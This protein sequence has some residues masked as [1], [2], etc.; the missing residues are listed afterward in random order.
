MGGVWFPTAGQL[1]AQE[2]THNCD[3]T[4]LRRT[5]AIP[6][7]L[8]TSLAPIV[9][10]ASLPDSVSSQLMS[11]KNLTGTISN[12]DLE[13]AATLVHKDVTAQSFGICETTCPW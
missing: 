5:D 12:S 1:H 10:G 2:G 8:G 7:Q 6:L 3:G 4:A 9:W 13:L 11:D